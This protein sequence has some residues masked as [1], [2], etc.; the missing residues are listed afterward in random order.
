M[1]LIIGYGEGITRT[2]E[3]MKSLHGRQEGEKTLDKWGIK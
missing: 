2:Q 1:F 3:L